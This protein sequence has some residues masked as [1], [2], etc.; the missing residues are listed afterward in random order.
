M[1]LA[2]PLS[3]DCTGQVTEASGMVFAV[4]EAWHQGPS[5]DPV[6]DPNEVGASMRT[7]L[8]Q[9]RRHATMQDRT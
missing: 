3:K 2:S 4:A 8:G 5:A 1:W 9:A 7:M 6:L